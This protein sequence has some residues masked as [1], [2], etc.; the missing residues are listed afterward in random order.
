[1]KKE[2]R[3][4]TKNGTEVVIKPI[5]AKIQ[6]ESTFVYNKAFSNALKNGSLLRQKL[7]RY[8][9]EQG[10][11][12]DEVQAEYEELLKEM[13]SIEKKLN[14]GKDENDKKIKLSEGKELALQLS[15]LRGKLTKILQ[16]KNSLDS[17]TAEA[18]AD[19]AQFNF[20]LVKSCYDYKT[21]TPLFSSEEEYI[22]KGD[23]EFSIEV[24][25]KFAEYYYDYD[26][27]HEKQR[28]EFKFLKRFDFIDDEGYY[29]NSDGERIDSKGNVIAE[30]EEDEENKIDVMVAEFED[31]INPKPATKKRKAA[32]SSE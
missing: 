29:I 11:W 20:Y 13:G 9:I 22:D 2:T 7:E 3:F 8:M 28:T 32:K 5:N 19:N 31:D 30:E 21:Q 27:E 17:S 23:E 6:N 4:T 1:M 18:L 16:Q 10:M 26:S 25:T 24:A 12:G 15:K 14:S